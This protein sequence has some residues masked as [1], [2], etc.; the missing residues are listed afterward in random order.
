MLERKLL[1]LH[2]NQIVRL[3]RLRFTLQ[4]IRLM[5][6]LNL[7]RILVNLRRTIG[8]NVVR[9]YVVEVGFAVIVFDVH[10]AR[11]ARSVVHAV[12]FIL[13]AVRQSFA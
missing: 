5:L 3:V 10:E 12:H 4:R 11:C 7:V 8:A 6:H 13:V 2:L 1:R 9:T